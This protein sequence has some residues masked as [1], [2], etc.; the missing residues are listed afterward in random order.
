MKLKIKIFQ[1]IILCISMILLKEALTSK[2]NTHH[3]SKNAYKSLSK[4]R[5]KSKSHGF[6]G[7]MQ[8]ELHADSKFYNNFTNIIFLILLILS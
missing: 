5:N 4:N 6:N 3:K 7:L 2:V 1:C 8:N